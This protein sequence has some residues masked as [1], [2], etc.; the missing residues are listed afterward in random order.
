VLKHTFKANVIPPEV[1]VPRYQSIMDANE[2]RRLQVKATSIELTRKN[3]KPFSFYERDKLKQRVG[4][5][6][7]EQKYRSDDLR[8]GGFKANPIPKAC[9]V[10]I[11]REMNEERE[12]QRKERITKNAALNHQKAK[13]P[14]R[15]EMHQR[16]KEQ[17]PPQVQV[18]EHYGFSFRPQINGLVT[19][20]EFKKRQDSF[21]KKLNRKKAQVSSTIP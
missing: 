4:D 12:K 3:E 8:F 6:V 10:Q 7:L 16:K 14:P 15:M 2:Q 13:L 19:A 1:L 17:L 9:T 18:Q 11:F 20:A 5:P 21:N